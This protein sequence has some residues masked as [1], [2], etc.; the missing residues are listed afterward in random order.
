MAVTKIKSDI[1]VASNMPFASE[2]LMNL[3]SPRNE[4]I[5]LVGGKSTARKVLEMKKQYLLTGRK[6][7][8]RA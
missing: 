8:V 5:K 6:H 1:D 4:M 7:N 3:I 2:F